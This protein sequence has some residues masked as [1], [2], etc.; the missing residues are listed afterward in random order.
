M[1]SENNE[2]SLARLVERQAEAMRKLRESK[3]ALSAAIRKVRDS[4]DT[5]NLGLAVTEMVKLAEKLE[6]E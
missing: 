3:E 1:P 4:W 2:D 5:G 6:G